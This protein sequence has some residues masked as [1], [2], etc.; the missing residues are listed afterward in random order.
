MQLPI[1]KSLKSRKILCVAT[2]ALRDAPNKKEFLNNSK[3]LRDYLQNG[4]SKNVAQII[5]NGKILRSLMWWNSCSDY[6]G[7][8]DHFEK[9]G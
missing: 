1:A 3:V 8:R 9:N 5:L 6:R 2:S 7:F 4:S